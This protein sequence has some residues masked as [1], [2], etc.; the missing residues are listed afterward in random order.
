M[1]ACETNNLF[2][3]NSVLQLHR[4]LDV[5][6]RSVTIRMRV[7]ECGTE[8]QNRKNFVER[9]MEGLLHGVSVFIDQDS[10]SNQY[11]KQCSVC[12]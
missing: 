4:N 11:S 3:I 5:R 8:K 2:Q 9:K 7:C 10:V 6:L 12:L 1:L